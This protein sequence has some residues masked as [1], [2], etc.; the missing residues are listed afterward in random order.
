MENRTNHNRFVAE[1]DIFV[2]RSQKEH[3]LQAL[4]KVE[5]IEEVYDVAGEVDIVS[6]VSASSLEEFSQIRKKIM[7]IKG[8]KSTLT[9]VVL[10]TH[11]R[12]NSIHT[13]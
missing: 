7:R 11:K 3:V 2:D 5:D 13:F 12:L 9:S 4:S 6:I 1:V 10:K 8:I